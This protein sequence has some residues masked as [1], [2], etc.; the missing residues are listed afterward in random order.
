MN[1]INKLIFGR[2]LPGNSF[3]HRMDPRAKLLLSFYFVLVVFI[4]N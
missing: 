2:Y 3:I 4:A 1:I